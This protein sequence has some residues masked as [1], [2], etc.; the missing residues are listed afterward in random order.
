MRTLRFKQVDVFTTVSFRGNPVAVVLQ[1][2]GLSGEDMQRIAGWT[3]LSETT[4][5][6]EPTVA[7]ADY[8]LRIFTPRDELPFAGH[9]TIGSAHAV[10]EAGLVTPRDGRF[11]QECGAGVLELTETR[12]VIEVKAPR[13]NVAPL[14]AARIPELERTLRGKVHTPPRIVSVGPVWL[15]ADLGT[16]AAVDALVPDMAAI[17]AFADS[18]RATGLT[19]FGATGQPGA[20]IHVRSFAPSHGVPEDPV[21]GSGNISVAAFLRESGQ[22]TR[23]GAAYRSRQGMQMGRDGSVSIRIGDDG[24]HLGGQAVTCVEGALRVQ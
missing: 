6:L 7:G 12:G 17:G 23:F 20:A 8:R 18:I 16:A 11:R 3:N 15:I 10:L 22:A 21:C 1:A 13:A 14:D 2:D 19:V 9:P 24:I 5:V 4:F